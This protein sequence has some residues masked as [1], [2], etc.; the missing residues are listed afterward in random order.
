V[1]G[2]G[3]NR[4]PVYNNLKGGVAASGDFTLAFSGY[5]TLKARLDKNEIQMIVKAL[6]V[7]PQQKESQFASPVVMFKEFQATRILLTI[8]DRGA[9][10]SP[11]FVKQLEMMVEISMFEAGPA[12]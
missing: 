9:P 12:T 1:K 10:I 4:S 2:D 3:S 7:D 11:D 6:L 5:N 8:F